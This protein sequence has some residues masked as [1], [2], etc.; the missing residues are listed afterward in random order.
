[1]HEIDRS[2][3]RIKKKID[4]DRDESTLGLEDFDSK[5]QSIEKELSDIAGAR[6]RTTIEFDSD[7]KNVIV[8]QI[9]DK[10]DKDITKTSAHLE[11][12]KTDID[13]T[14]SAIG[15]LERELTNVYEPFIGKGNLNLTVV[16]ALESLINTNEADT[17]G[18][19]LR[20]YEMRTSAGRE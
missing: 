13:S 15:S 1:M 17:I 19:A 10:Y 8:G 5:L 7:V 16:N 11:R 18:D 2:I 12:V 9:A 14:Q 6:K 3:A 4:K 20:V